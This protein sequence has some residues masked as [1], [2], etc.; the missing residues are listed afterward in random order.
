MQ[1]YRLSID[2]LDWMGPATRR[3]AQAK[4]ERLRPKIGYP[5]RWTCYAALDI[6]EG[7]LVG[8]LMRARR[9]EHARQLA[10]LGAPIDRDE[11]FMT[12]QTVN[13]YYDPSMNEIVFPASILKPP[14]FDADAD[15]AVNFGA[16]GAVIG[17]EI[18]HGF[19]DQGSQYDSAGQLRDWWNAEDRARFDAR[20]RRLV[21]QYGAYVPLPGYPLNGE[22]SLG[23]NIADNSGLAIAWKAYRLALGEGEAPVIDGRS[24]AERFFFG[25]AQV[26]RGKSRDEALIQ[27]IKAG[28]HAPAEFRANGTVRNHPGF[29]ATFGVQPGDAMYLAR[30]ERVSIW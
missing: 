11:W 14:F 26:W 22:L 21:A 12:P 2:E 1:A 25:F 8:N 6:R 19:D 13:A 20:T 18:S 9:F 5:A 17:H 4:L 15:D 29:H 30:E 27:Q 28:P 24:G 3:E 10:K 23:E 7:D 16:I